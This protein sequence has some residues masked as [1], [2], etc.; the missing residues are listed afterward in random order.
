MIKVQ[1]QDGTQHEITKFVLYDYIGLEKEYGIS[2][3]DV[4]DAGM[5]THLAFLAW[6]ALEKR[7]KVF[8]GGFQAFCEQVESVES[9]DD[10]EDD[11]AAP[12]PSS[13][14]DQPTG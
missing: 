3:K 13:E 7:L 9:P 8:T 6:H 14:S 5:L 2:V 12:S 4:G 11:E 10:E 1:M